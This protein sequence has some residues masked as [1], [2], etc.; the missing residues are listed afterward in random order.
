MTIAT[1]TAPIV[2]VRAEAIFAAT[3]IKSANDLPD[4]TYSL[5][6]NTDESAFKYCI[7]ARATLN[8]EAREYACFQF[9]RVAAGETN[10]DR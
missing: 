3:P 1:Y 4:E 5:A 7:P 6:H 8:N 9:E 2:D 10:H